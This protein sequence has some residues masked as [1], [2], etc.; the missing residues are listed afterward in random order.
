MKRLAIAALLVA[1][2]SPPVTRSGAADDGTYAMATDV[3]PRTEARAALARDAWRRQERM[4]DALDPGRAL[5]S[6]MLHDDEITAG[7]VTPTELFA[8]GGGLFHHRFLPSEGAPAT[9]SRFE[10]RTHP[11]A[12]SCASCHLRGGAAGS[13]SSVDVAYEGGDG[14]RWSSAVQRRPPSLI[15]GAWLELVASE[16]TRELAALRDAT[17]DLS[18]TQGRDVTVELVTH[19]VSFGSLTVRADG[20]VATEAIEGVDPDLIVRPFG[21][22]GSLSTAI[23][24]ELARRLGVELTTGQRTA[25]VTYL[26]LLAPPIEELP[27]TSDYA[28]SAARGRTR[29]DVLGC[30][31]CHVA[32][33]PVSATTYTVGLGVSVTLD[34]DGEPPRLS[35]DALDGRLVVRAY[36]DL[37]RHAM[38]AALADADT[39][40]FVTPALWGLSVRAPYLHDARAG[41][42]EDA[43][44]AH[45]G[46]AQSARDAYA[47]LADVDRG[48]LRM[49]LATLTRTRRLEVP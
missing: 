27:T 19:G 35:R 13:G 24:G 48:D 12:S 41:S 18:H 20:T 9:L 3:D 14:E 45:G 2:A 4:L 39:D 42:V 30:S 25:L 34:V 36:T 43:I 6:T 23:D 38:G 44:M 29:F 1:C 37:R 32:E 22:Y 49:F 40:S 11:A 31:S 47:A 7:L 17:R 28:L 46:E 33:L 16:M 21:T 8:I 15:G 26:A 5:A 10:D